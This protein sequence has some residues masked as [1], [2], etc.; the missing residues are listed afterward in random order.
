MHEEFEDLGTFPL[1]SNNGQ[2]ASSTTANIRFLQL[3]DLHCFPKDCTHFQNIP[4]L[5]AHKNCM[6]LIDQ[7]VR[8]VQPDVIVLTGDIID[9][10]GPW[11]SADSVVDILQDMLPLFHGIPW[12]YIPGNHDD[13]QSPWTRQ[14]LTKIIKLQGCLQNGAQGFHHTLLLTKNNGNTKVRLYLFDSGG[15]HPNPKYMYYCTPERAVK[16]FEQFVLQNANTEPDVTGICYIHIPTPEYQHL[17]PVVGRNNLFQAALVGGKIPSPL[18]KLACLIRFLKMDRIA[19]CTR[20]PDSGLFSALCRANQNGTNIMSV[21]CGHDHHS[22]AI[23]WKNGIFLGYGRSGAMT[24]PFDWEGKA[25][26]VMNPGARVVE[27]SQDGVVRT[28]IQTHFGAEDGS[29]LDMVR[30]CALR[31]CI[32]IP[33]ICRCTDFRFRILVQFSAVSDQLRSL[34]KVL[35]LALMG[36]MSKLY[37]KIL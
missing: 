27:V 14:D 17:D 35:L 15:N 36:P 6:D 4:L 9:G 30:F 26:N 29:F 10:R 20:G 3:T 32:V 19:G 28:W 21:F 13:D 8:Q 18:D 22:D 34:P 5:D 31:V 16:G 33:K 37:T 7:L 2:E 23:F 11:P 1:R 12:A 25:P 24:P